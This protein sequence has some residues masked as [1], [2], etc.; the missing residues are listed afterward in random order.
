ME[1]IF[2]EEEKKAR[3]EEK[4]ANRIECVPD[5]ED[6][7]LNEM[8]V[9]I[10]RTENKQEMQ[11]TSDEQDG[12]CELSRALAVLAS[13]SVWDCSTQLLCLNNNSCIILY[14]PCFCA[15]PNRLS[16]Q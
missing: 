4:K 3:E 11:R 8:T 15:L 6:L 14:L 7:A 2:Q 12:L 16:S 9:P 1:I 5:R 10:A 13:A